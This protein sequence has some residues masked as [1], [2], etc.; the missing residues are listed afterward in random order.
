MSYTRWKSQA[1]QTIKRF[2][3]TAI[4]QLG[5]GALLPPATPANIIAAPLS[6]SGIRVTWAFV[7][8]AASFTVIRTNPD[9]ST[10][11]FTGLTAES[12]DDTGL[13]AMTAY[14]YT[15]ISVN[16][17]GSSAASGSVS[18]ITRQQSSVLERIVAA[19]IQMIA[20]QGEN[21][22]K[23]PG[24]GMTKDGG[25]I[26]DW[27][28]ADIDD[29][30]RVNP[31][32]GQAWAFVDLAKETNQD[33]MDTMS[34]ETSSQIV[35]VEVSIYCQLDQVYLDPPQIYKLWLGRA[36]EDVKK[37]FMTNYG[38]LPGSGAEQICYVDA[39]PV[40]DAAGDALHPGK[41]KTIWEVHYTQDRF[42]PN[43]TY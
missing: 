38:L 16:A 40:M 35:N 3:T 2:K 42:N 18:A 31:Q 41:L 34:P 5:G 36:L 15:V 13:I 26:F 20:G 25:Y 30:G 11:T 33:K 19:M 29:I 10:T 1:S 32:S 17:A 8:T 12:F 9:T 43:T 24:F 14:S 7:P 4:E 6:M 22:V 21:R 37:L 23:I 39:T 28:S 27:I